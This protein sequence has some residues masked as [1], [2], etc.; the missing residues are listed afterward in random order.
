MWANLLH[1]DVNFQDFFSSDLR[2]ETPAGERLCTLV[3]DFVAENHFFVLVL[4]ILVSEDDT[5]ADGV[6]KVVNETINFALH[7]I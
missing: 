7:C 1:I 2:V 6:V 5:R 3:F 4:G